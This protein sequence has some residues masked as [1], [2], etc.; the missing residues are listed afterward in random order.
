MPFMVAEHVVIGQS[1]ALVQNSSLIA[2]VCYGICRRCVCK[3]DNN[4]ILDA[5]APVIEVAWF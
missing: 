3:A 5:D 4:G 2:V 1:F